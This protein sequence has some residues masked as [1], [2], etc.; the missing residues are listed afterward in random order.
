MRDK[1]DERDRYYPV[2]NSL[3][4]SVSPSAFVSVTSVSSVVQ[5]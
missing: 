1:G 2:P 4:L 5:K 3:N